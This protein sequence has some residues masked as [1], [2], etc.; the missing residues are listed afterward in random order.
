MAAGLSILAVAAACLI[1]WRLCLGAL[2]RENRRAV[3]PPDRAELRRAFDAA[4]DWLHREYPTL[5]HGNVYLW[6]MVREAA[7]ISGDARLADILERHRAH[8][9]EHVHFR[10]IWYLMEHPEG[11]D[12]YFPDSFA[13]LQDYK[14]LTVY[15]LTGNTELAESD[16]IRA[17]LEPDYCAAETNADV[18]SK[19]LTHQALG[20]RFVQQSGKCGPPEQYAAL[21]TALLAQIRAQTERDPRVSDVYLQRVLM[22]VLCGAREQVEPIWI[23]RILEMQQP[24]GGWRPYHRLGPFLPGISLGA[25][26]RYFTLKRDGS[27]FHST[28]QGVLLL[29]LL[30]S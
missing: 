22:L 9:R 30:L 12:E 7:E 4:A 2:A 10:D 26:T 17:M 14:K 11:Q 13:G 27:T 16:L 1:A 5:Y 19:C 29:A 18:C 25:G 3:S 24:D 20:L 15:G 6:W 21:M 23:Q 28:A 8:Q